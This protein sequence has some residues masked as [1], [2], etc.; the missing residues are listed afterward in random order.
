MIAKLIVHA[1]TREEAAAALARACGAVEV[2]PV[3]TNAAF[4]ARC[5]AD[6]DFVA[7]AVDTGFIEER[8]AALTPRPSRPS[9][10]PPS[11][12]SGVRSDPASPWASVDR[13]SSERPGRAAR[14]RVRRR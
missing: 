12:L 9:P 6:P 11:A 2:W 14:A 5:A 8:L 7:G 10:P 4:L 1:D 13:L 3:K